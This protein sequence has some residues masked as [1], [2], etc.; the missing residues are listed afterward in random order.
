MKQVS[1]SWWQAGLVSIDSNIRR[2]LLMAFIMSERGLLGLVEYCLCHSVK[3]R[4]LSSLYASQG[5]D[6][7]LPSLTVTL[8]YSELV[9]L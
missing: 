4:R 1:P 7:T 3:V 2:E 8:P 6:L 5:N 9:I